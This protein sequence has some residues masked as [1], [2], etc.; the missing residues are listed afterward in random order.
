MSLI[1]SVGEKKW[2]QY[3]TKTNIKLQQ[4]FGK[5]IPPAQNTYFKAG[6]IAVFPLAANDFAASEDSCCFLWISDHSMRQ[7]SK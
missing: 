1:L 5:E 2:K 3:S 7:I 6:H 4:I